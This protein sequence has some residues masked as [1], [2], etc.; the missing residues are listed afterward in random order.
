MDGKDIALIKALSG[1]GSGGG[2]PTGG[3]PYQQLVTDGEGK[4]TWEDRLAYETKQLTELIQ[5]QTAEFALQHGLY[6]SIIESTSFSTLIDGALL[7]FV[8]DGKMYECTVAEVDTDVFMGGNLSILGGGA[9]TGEP[10]AAQ[11]FR[12]TG[13]LQLITSL[14]DVNH[15]IAVFSVAKDVKKLDEKFMPVLTSPN[16]KK[17]KITVDDSGTISA[18]E[19]TS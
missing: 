11:I 18:T 17:F 8:F 12:D 14:T 4:A 6:V 10:F 2:L 15:S 7:G 16:G 13:E 3:A 5:E 1:G 19:V 9:D